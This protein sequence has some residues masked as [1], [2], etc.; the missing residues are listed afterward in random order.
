MKTIYEM[1]TEEKNGAIIVTLVEKN[2]AIIVT[3]NVAVLLL[4]V[5]VVLLSA[6]IYIEREELKRC[7]NPSAQEIIAVPSDD[8]PYDLP[9]DEGL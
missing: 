2:R 5:A 7:M 1:F 9:K 8:Y 6:G 3:L 4:I